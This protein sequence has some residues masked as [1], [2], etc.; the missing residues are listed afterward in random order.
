[1]LPAS[2]VRH[3]D[4]LPH[5]AGVVESDVHAGAAVRRRDAD[6][7]RVGACGRDVDGVVQPFAGGDPPDVVIA[8]GRGLD[9]H[10]CR[11]IGAA[12]IAWIVVVIG[13]ALAAV[14]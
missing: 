4:R 3:A 14:V 5:V 9:V 1:L 12:E 11:A 13:H 8:V 2:G 10:T 7:D 6:G